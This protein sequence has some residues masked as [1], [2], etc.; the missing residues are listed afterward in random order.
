MTNAEF[1]NKYHN[2]DQLLF[3]FA[4]RLT[5]NRSD[6]DDLMQETVLRAFSNKDRFKTGTNFKAWMT[7]I[8]RNTF[9]NNYR[10]RRTRNNV[11]QSVDENIEAIRKKSVVNAAESTLAAEEIQQIVDEL[12]DGSRI[13]FLMFFQGFHYKEIAR[14]MDLKMGT[15][16][17]RIFFAR[18]KIKNEIQ[19]RYGKQKINELLVQA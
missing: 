19:A 2:L 14:T 6:A 16:K 1:L 13:P 12:D 7:T 8:M 18:K 17:S 11:E 3:A 4:M 9:I 15:V 5:K 10:K